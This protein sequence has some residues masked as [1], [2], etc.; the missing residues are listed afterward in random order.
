MPAA[1]AFVPPP[2]PSLPPPPS[3][4]SKMAAAGKCGVD[5]NERQRKQRWQEAAAARLGPLWE[6]CMVVKDRSPGAGQQAGGGAGRSPAFGSGLTALGS[7][8]ELRRAAL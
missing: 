1:A 4:D 5:R 7:G 3:S 6:R 8:A 2:S